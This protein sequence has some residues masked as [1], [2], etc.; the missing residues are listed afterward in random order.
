MSPDAKLLCRSEKANGGATSPEDGKG[1]HLKW[2]YGSYDGRKQILSCGCQM[3][4]MLRFFISPQ[5]VLIHFWTVLRSFGSV[6]HFKMHTFVFFAVFA[7]V[8]LAL[9]FPLTKRISTPVVDDGIILNYALTLEHL[10]TAFYQYGL[11]M[12]GQ[13]DFLS[14]GFEDPF[15]DTLLQIYLDGLTH[16]TFWTGALWAAG[17]EPTVELQYS[18]PVADP[19]SFVTM[20]GVFESLGVS[21]YVS[22][23]MMYSTYADRDQL[24]WTIAFSSRQRLLDGMQL[25]AW[26]H[27]ASCFL[28][29]SVYWRVA[30]PIPFRYTSLIRMYQRY[31]ICNLIQD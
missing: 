28:L 10:K 31:E 25:G 16:V 14:A 2:Y 4:S 1:N 9:P 23:H 17:I 21:A 19:E 18:F 5:I 30:V 22:V 11:A 6:F 8:R 29:T 26:C 24:S 15:Y 20:A 3:S 7:L 27:R 13:G 12:Y